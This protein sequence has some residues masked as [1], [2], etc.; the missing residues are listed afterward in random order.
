MQRG[1]SYLVP[2]CLPNTRH[3]SRARIDCRDVANGRYIATT[4]RPRYDRG[5]FEYVLEKVNYAEAV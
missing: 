4:K 5:R 1:T 2:L 3:A